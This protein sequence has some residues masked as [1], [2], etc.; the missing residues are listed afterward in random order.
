MSAFGRFEIL[1]PLRYNDGRPVPEELL[2]DAALEIQR[3]FGAVSWE[4]QVIEGRWRLA[5]VEYRDTLNRIF[6]DLE[7]TP[8]NRRF[9]MQLKDRL[10]TRFQ[11]LDIWV[12]VHPIE[13]L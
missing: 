8:E 2:E 6:V 12:T 10:K 3:S 9:F 1:L 5:G 7:D 11:Q 13:V 4:S